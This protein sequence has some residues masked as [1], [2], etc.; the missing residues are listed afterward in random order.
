MENDLYRN[1]NPHLHFFSTSKKNQDEREKDKELEIENISKKKENI[2]EIFEDEDF[3]DDGQ[4]SETNNSDNIF[5]IEKKENICDFKKYDNDENVIT[6]VKIAT[7][8]ILNKQPFSVKRSDLFNI[9]NYHLPNCFRSYAKRQV[10]IEVTKKYFRENLGLD[11]LDIVHN[12]SKE[13]MLSQT[14]LYEPHN[15]LLLSHLDHTIR[16]FLIFLFPFF[17]IYKNKIPLG[18][19]L[20]T[21]EECGW[22]SAKTKKEIAMYIFSQKQNNKDN[23]INMLNEK[24]AEKQDVDIMYLLSYMKLLGY[25]DIC[26]P[27]S[28]KEY[29]FDDFYCMAS[30][31]YEQEFCFDSYIEKLLQIPDKDYYVT[32]LNH[33]FNEN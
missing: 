5:H 13:Y 6:A 14:I 29:I 15:N 33:I 9:I 30:S 11:L 27:K 3:S 24:N 18:H 20:L 4:C 10:V 26:S 23:L 25:I 1:F 19:L 32:D 31:R 22:K 21:L 28:D 17:Q 12:N 7:Q 8:Y 16:G 2:N